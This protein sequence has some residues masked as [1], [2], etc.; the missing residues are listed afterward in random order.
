MASQQEKGNAAQIIQTDE[1]EGTAEP[2]CEACQK[3]VIQAK[4]DKKF[5]TFLPIGRTGNPLK[6][7]RVSQGNLNVNG[8][9][10]NILPK[11]KIEDKRKCSTKN[12]NR[13][14]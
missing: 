9:I 7:H 6:C 13:R 2:V 5:H 10:V 4:H 8:Y 12:T 1:Y 11:S 14:I 3:N